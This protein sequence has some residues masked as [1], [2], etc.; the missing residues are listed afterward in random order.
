MKA[1][2]AVEYNEPPV[3]VLG[4]THWIQTQALGKF[5]F[6]KASIPSSMK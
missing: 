2:E 6:F 3:Q 5:K 4:Q 1:L